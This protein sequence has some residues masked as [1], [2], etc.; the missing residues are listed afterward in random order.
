[1]TQEGDPTNPQTYPPWK[2]LPILDGPPVLRPVA[3]TLDGCIDLPPGSAATLGWI[4]PDTGDIHTA[5]WKK[6]GDTG[7]YPASTIKWITAF[8]AIQWLE[9][10]S[11]G[12]SHV[13]Q[14][15]DDPP[16]T[17]H[18][19][20]AG[21]VVMSDNEA[22][23]TLQEL[24]GFEHT[25]RTMRR[26]GCQTGIIRRHFTRP[27]WNHSR[28]AEVWD[29]HGERVLVV[30]AR[31]AVDLPLNNDPVPDSPRESNW[32]SCDDFVR[33][34]AATLMG[35]YRELPLFDA[36]TGWLGY[37]N[38]SAIREG[39]WRVTRQDPR[40]PGFAVLNKPGWWPGDGANCEL[41]YIYDAQERRHYLLAIYF[42]GEHDD[43]MQCMR[44]AA[45]SFFTA[46]RAGT[47]RTD[48]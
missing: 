26:W 47:L 42:Q 8:L 3:A 21:M 14:V 48:R 22:F 12:L 5:H 46:I 29:E 34:A 43:A 31:P 39:L 16:R 41:T 15:G 17:V 28:E 11:I 27:H 45:E 37:T 9:E 1:M 6:T 38:Q 44:S 33:C 32:F 20:L 36:L 30:P 7:F 2:R 10:N 23:N 18:D 4:D 35:P 13:V 19:L 25:Y 24:V 40:H